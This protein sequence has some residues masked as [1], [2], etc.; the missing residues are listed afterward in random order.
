MSLCF[1]V[2]YVHILAKQMEKN[3]NFYHEHMSYHS[4]S[5]AA[6]DPEGEADMGRQY[7]GE[8][9]GVWYRVQ[10]RLHA[11]TGK[12]LTWYRGSS[13]W[14]RVQRRL[15]AATGKHLTWFR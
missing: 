7:H 11:P 3:V 6:K 4:V 15:H 1:S 13:V 2:V 5:A 8:E 9:A 12:H 10:R 14:Y